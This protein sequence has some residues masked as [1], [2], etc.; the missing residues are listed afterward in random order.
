MFGDEFYD[1]APKLGLAGGFERK[2]TTVPIDVDGI[3]IAVKSAIFSDLVCD[4]HVELLMF[5]FS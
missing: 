1:F 2:L 4:D 3:L 5:E